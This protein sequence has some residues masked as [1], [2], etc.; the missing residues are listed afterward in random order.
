VPIVHVSSTFRV[1]GK[2]GCVFP[3]ILA[4]VNALVTIKTPL[5]IAFRLCAIEQ[6]KMQL[7]MAFG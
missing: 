3:P 6:I 7:S 1:I 2:Q 5:N 4:I